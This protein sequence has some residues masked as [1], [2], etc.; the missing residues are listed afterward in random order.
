VRQLAKGDTF[1][2][3]G[4]QALLRGLSSAVWPAVA[5]RLLVIAATT[6]VKVSQDKSLGAHIYCKPRAHIYIALIATVAGDQPLFW[7]PSPALWLAV[8]RQLLAIAKATEGI[9]S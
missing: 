5:R 1:E 3:A 2:I 6:G 4:D 9:G 8:A 7:G